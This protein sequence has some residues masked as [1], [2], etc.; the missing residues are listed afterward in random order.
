M[1]L[2]NISQPCTVALQM[3]LVDLLRS[4]GVEPTAVTSHSSGEIAAA[5]AVGAL[6]FAEAL[7][8][9]YYRGEYA[10]KHQQEALRLHGPGGMIA[11]GLSAEKADEY[12]KKI[13][14]GRLV[15]ACVNSPD[16]V[17]ISGDAVALDEVIQILAAEDIFARKLQVP[18]AYHSH[19]M[20][21]MA[22]DYLTSLKALLP[23]TRQWS[24][25]GVIFSS[26]V[27]GSR[28]ASPKSL[29]AEHWVSNLT[30]PVL[31]AQAFDSMCFQTSAR[32]KPEIDLVV[33]IGA[34]STLSGPIRQIMENQTI[35]YVSCL[36]RGADAVHT[37]QD[38]ACELVARGEPVALR[39]VNS[40]CGHGG[41]KFVH[42]LPCYPWNHEKQYWTESRRYKEYRDG[43]YAAHELLGVL[44][45]GANPITPTWR[46]FLRIADIPWLADHQL[47]SKIVLPGAEYV[48]MA[49][50]AVHLITDA[51]EASIAGYRL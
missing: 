48:A 36:K 23:D 35:S 5:Y 40:V 25:N 17:T 8:V 11:A 1:H 12:I 51:T 15:V 28:L 32:D 34:H 16:S 9:V 29:G 49:I 47:D 19:H 2:I 10:L 13:T 27:T 14:V 43:R 38:T 42:G 26:P 33:E 3:C 18:L 37:M 7:G 41:H 30:S 22:N 50:E 4:W 20:D 21:A 45:P 44:V 39:E 46:S 24:W 31:F 6:T